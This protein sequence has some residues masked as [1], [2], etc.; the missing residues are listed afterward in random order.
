MNDHKIYKRPGY[1]CIRGEAFAV[2]PVFITLIRD[3]TSPTRPSLL[4]FQPGNSG[5]NMAAFHFRRGSQ[6]TTSSLCRVVHAV[7]CT[8][9][10]FI[11]LP[12]DYSHFHSISQASLVWTIH[13][14]LYI[15]MAIIIHMI[16]Y[17]LLYLFRCIDDYYI[18]K[19]V[20]VFAPFLKCLSF[21]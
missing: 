2:P 17:E 5:V 19:A 10:V 15:S 4:L 16:H 7:L 12:F 1:L 6:P 13:Q 9:I 11:Q 18:H 14:I 8:I 20:Y 21:I 3:I